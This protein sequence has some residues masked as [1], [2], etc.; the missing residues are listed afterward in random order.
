MKGFDEQNNLRRETAVYELFF[1]GVFWGCYVQYPHCSFMK[2]SLM[3]DIVPQGIWSWVAVSFNVT[4]LKDWATKEDQLRDY[5]FE[6]KASA[7][8]MRYVYLQCE[9]L[10]A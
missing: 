5:T 9:F 3:M 2:T 4:P 6:P 8:A 7:N 10:M 1:Q